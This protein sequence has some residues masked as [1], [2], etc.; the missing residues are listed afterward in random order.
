MK[1]STK[2]LATLLA[3]TI[4][5]AALINFVLAPKL[6]QKYVQDIEIQ[7][8]ISLESNI[9]YLDEHIEDIINDMNYI[10]TAEKH[11]VY[12]EKYYT[13]YINAED[14]DF[15]Y[16][17]NENEQM[18]QQFL[19]EY[20]M[21]NADIE[22]IFIGLEDG[23]F[24]TDDPVALI[25]DN[26]SEIYSYDPRVR[27]WYKKAIESPDD[28]I[29]SPLYQRIKLLEGTDNTNPINYYLTVAR[30]VKNE[31]GE[32][33]GAIGINIGLHRILDEI[34]V[35]DYQEIKYLGIMFNENIACILR[36]GDLLIDPYFSNSELKKVLT[37]LDGK[38]NNL[39]DSDIKDECVI[40]A[41]SEAIES[42][43]FYVA[44]GEMI[45]EKINEYI[46]SIIATL[47]VSIL[48]FVLMILTFINI[49]IVHPMNKLKKVTTSITETMDFTQKVKYKSN[50]E[51][52]ELADNFNFMMDEI[53]A[54]RDNMD[55]IVKE[56][57][58][59]L[60]KFNTVIE[61]SPISV[62]IMDKMGRVEYINPE[63][64][65]MTG[66]GLE[67]LKGKRMP[68]MT[69]QKNRKEFFRNIFEMA[70]IG[71]DWKGVLESTKKNGEVFYE[72]LMISSI[73]DEN[74]EISNI[75]AIIED[76]T[77]F[78]KIERNL[79]ALFENMP[80]GFAEHEIIYDENGE[81]VDY[82]YL[83]INE[84]FK[85]HTGLTDEVLGKTVKELL[86]GTEDR[87]ITIYDKV[88]RTQKPK[89]F[90]D[91]ARE[92]K[93]Y[94]RVTAFPTGKKTF[95]TIFDDITES[96][97]AEMLIEENEKR[98]RYIFETTPFAVVRTVKGIVYY[99]NKNFA[100][101]TGLKMKDSIVEAYYDPKE[102][103]EI[104]KK[105]NKGEN[106]LNREVRLKRAN[107][108]MFY[109]LIS[110]VR[111]NVLGEAGMLAWLMDISEI[112]E[113]E[114][115]LI[116]AKEQA[117]AATQ[118]KSD[119]LANMSHEIRTPMNAVIGLNSLLKSTK[120]DTK[121]EDYVDKIERSASRLLNIINDILDFSKI[122]SGK[123]ELENIEFDIDEAMKDQISVI[124]MAAY[125]KNIEILYDKDLN[126]P[127]KV[128][129]DLHKLGQVLGNLMNNAVKFTEKGHVL[130]KARLVEKNNENIKVKFTVSDTG[131]GMD[132]KQISQLFMPFTQADTSTTR[133]YG[134]TGLGLVITKELVEM[135]GGEIRVSSKK[136]K[137]SKFEFEIN[138]ISIGS[139]EE[140]L[141]IKE[142]KKVMLIEENKL[143]R[144]V[145]CKYINGL[146]CECISY[147]SA[148]KTSEMSKEGC[149]DLVIINSAQ[150]DEGTE[151][152]EKIKEC[153]LNK[154]KPK[155]I[156][157]QSV[158]YELEDYIK[159]GDEDT[160]LVKPI[161]PYTL[162]EAINEVFEYTEIAKEHNDIKESHLE[163]IK[164]VE[165]ANILVVEDNEIN[166]LVICDLLKNAGFK[167]DEAENGREA[168][169]MIGQNSYDLVLMDIQMPELDGYEATKI[170]R[171]KYS[172][173]DLPII[174]LTADV[175]LETRR[176]TFEIGMNDFLS[177]PIDM[178]MLY[179]KLMKWLKIKNLA[180]LA[181]NDGDSKQITNT[182]KIVLYDFDVDK[183]L[184]RINGNVI[185][186]IKTLNKFAAE[187]MDLINEIKELYNVDDAEKLM[188]IAHSQKGVSAYLGADELSGM[189]AKMEKRLKEKGVDKKIN[190]QIEEIEKAIKHIY[191]EIKILNKKFNEMDI[192]EN[193]NAKADEHEKIVKELKELI[194][195]LKK[196]D[197]KVVS[198]A[199]IL[200]NKVENKNIAGMLDLT[201]SFIDEKKFDRAQSIAMDI[202][203]LVE[204]TGI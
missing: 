104:H 156:L 118:A 135:M 69:N 63:Y 47:I 83:N 56:R 187:S 191:N 26:Q 181:V 198:L 108:E 98:L 45:D 166:R 70:I 85:K 200:K 60:A 19:Y 194:E 36:D 168:V 163:D 10:S 68:V 62:V 127:R 17:P 99:A 188:F 151:L 178:K 84:S 5:V 53:S 20:K 116:I 175:V 120:L 177:K 160:M 148:K 18:I 182:M 90:E 204:S 30:A 145:L 173:D 101:M 95:A 126:I 123:M 16:S 115:Q 113:A 155:V 165:N 77:D 109:A 50:D 59:E 23:S 96:K 121:Q 73:K 183:A 197:E 150:K 161:F 82:K 91:Y 40:K 21:Q 203:D 103:L 136:N 4:V 144:E 15:V 32:I 78:I 86:P 94:F 58:E 149:F 132:K 27:P 137:G 185:F 71:N 33:V 143:A 102:R 179:E 131:I 192:F 11:F 195:R 122:E 193:E 92:L 154:N 157:M 48:I 49:Y 54:Y 25:G 8:R 129:G 43:L 128:K 31:E 81:A 46:R 139:Q 44:N 141:K 134:G 52:G 74:G 38:S 39:C 140:S 65:H 170:I 142:C 75:I 97:K 153:R 79:T 117:E 176:K 172:K 125:G 152:L 184:S 1:L 199:K 111:M 169:D 42:T 100:K 167:V 66:Y 3:F 64:S 28:T 147:K 76:L 133:K 159:S 105:I 202:L 138:F 114:E 6:K 41:D 7:Y 190:G 106:V 13:S 201:I 14:E 12:G 24:I 164:E 29:V 2:V 89:T 61:Q 130:I 180:N 174:A 72:N 186:Y 67:E 196:S 87:W 162:Y 158:N 9:I 80:T 146:G 107:G 22:D 55:N 37:E 88:V 93:K 34:R 51:V 171:R 35:S 112:K 124:S 110:V 119:F 57:T 189:F